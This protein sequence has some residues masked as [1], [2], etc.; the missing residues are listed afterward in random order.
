MK[1]ARS[2][3]EQLARE[4]IQALK[5]KRKLSKREE[6]EDAKKDKESEALESNDPIQLQVKY[7]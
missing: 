1:G 6:D 7:R 3:Q 2:R 5:N 4:R